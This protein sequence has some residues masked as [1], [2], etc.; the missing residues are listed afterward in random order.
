MIDLKAKLAES[1]EAMQILRDHNVAVPEEAYEICELI[2]RAI[3]AEEALA[4]LRVSCDGCNMP[5]V[6][7]SPGRW[8]CRC[9][10]RLAQMRKIVVSVET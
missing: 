9:T 1:E 3:T 5:Y 4:K 6:E 2:R 10:C 8:A 7:E